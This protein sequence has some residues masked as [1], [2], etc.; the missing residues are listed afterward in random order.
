MLLIFA[1]CPTYYQRMAALTRRNIRTFWNGGDAVCRIQS[2]VVGSGEMKRF[3]FFEHTADIG[4]RVFGAT[5]EE[6]FVNAAAA[7]Y[8]AMGVRKKEEG[9]IRKEIRI[10]AESAED[11]LHDWL[12]ELLFELSAHGVIFDEIQ[13][14]TLN[15]QGF[16]AT[17]KG[18]RADWSEARAEVKAVT[19]HQ[20]RVEQRADSS[21]MA[22]VIF[23][24]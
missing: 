24:V 6:L 10:E 20:L 2:R 17:A 13:S 19:Y 4:V 12:A 3:E 9:R 8:E 11:L 7:L 18:G 23:D 15:A 1:S 16:E 22:T 21:W 5:L 14:A